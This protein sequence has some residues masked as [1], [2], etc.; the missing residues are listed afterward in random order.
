MSWLGAS[1]LICVLVTCPRRR[2][3]SQHLPSSALCGVAPVVVGHGELA[4]L[5]ISPVPLDESP[6]F[7]NWGQAPDPPTLAKARFCAP[8]QT[9]HNSVSHALPVWVIVAISFSGNHCSMLRIPR[10]DYAILHDRASLLCGAGILSHPKSQ[11]ELHVH[12][13]SLCVMHH[14]T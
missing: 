4:L 12:Q 6:S 9:D 10:S 1:F 7:A 14:S 8:R 13:S 5:P 3:P 2:R 11:D